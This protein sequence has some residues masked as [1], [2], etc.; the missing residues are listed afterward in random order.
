M[1]V[2]SGQPESAGAQSPRA[3][4]SSRGEG[5]AQLA[6]SAQAEGATP[7]AAA[8]ASHDGTGYNGAG[9]SDAVKDD[10]L[11]DGATE[12][13]ATGDLAGKD[14]PG[15]D[16]GGTDGPDTDDDEKAGSGSGTRP[17]KGHFWRDLA[18]IV[19]AALILTVVIKAFLFQVFSIPSASMQNTLQPGDRILVNRLVY[20]LRGIDRGDIVVFSGDG[21]WG[22]P[23]PPPPSN[24]LE[25]AWDDVTNYVGL[26]APGTDYVKRVIG[27]PGD[28]VKCCDVQGRITVN[29]VALNEGSYL[30]PGDTPN[31]DDTSWSVVVPAGR[32]FVL[33]DHRSDSCDSRCH[34]SQG[35]YG[36]IPENEVVGRAFVII[37]PFSR[38]NDLPIP[39][40]FQQAALHASAA[41]V[42][43]GPAAG[44]ASAAAGALA[45]RRRRASRR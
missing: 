26:S 36:T 20:D 28:H 21:S 25:R 15:K 32:L 22:P 34:M 40:T 45:W 3:A 39:S 2:D 31:A 11:N 43:Y 38:I 33:G 8:G 4:E 18:I 29:G 1:D 9:P 30:Y 5:S 6:G 7:N 16:G 42:T 17:R 23:P 24:P 13:G 37:W 41:A 35:E 27:L 12:D 44:G 19:V 10:A 14:G